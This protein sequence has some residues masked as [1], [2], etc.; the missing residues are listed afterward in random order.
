MRILIYGLGRSGTTALFTA[1]QQA[2]PELPT[3]FEPEDLARPAAVRGDLLVKALSLPRDAA[4]WAGVASFEK[5]ILLVRHPFDRMVSSLLYAPYAGRGFSD[6]RRADDFHAAILAKRRA[7]ERL[8]MAELLDR[9]ERHTGRRLDAAGPAERLLAAAV[10]EPGFFCLKYEDFV[11][12]RTEALAGYL[13]FP[14]ASAVRVAP[15]LARVHRRGGAGDWRNWYLASDVAAQAPGLAAFA[16]AFGYDLDFDPTH[17]PAI[18]PEH[19]EAFVLRNLNRYRRRY[20]L[21][22]FRP[23]RIR[24]GEEGALFDQAI[25]AFRHGDRAEGRALLGRALALNPRLLAAWLQRL[26]HSR[27]GER[28][29]GPAIALARRLGGRPRL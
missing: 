27:L 14:I 28:L 21:P 16:E 3:V 11:A 15:Y 13:G 4:V 29:G 12:G 19:A 7:P 9:L 1:I 6:D 22:R 23:G 26:R 5:R 8:A 24:M 20:L 18:E 10:G 2:R 25:W 17:R